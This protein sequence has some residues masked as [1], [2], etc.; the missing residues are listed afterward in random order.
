MWLGR[1]I[2][3]TVPLHMQDA[4]FRYLD[5]MAPD[6]NSFP[7]SCSFHEE[8]GISFGECHSSQVFQIE[9]VQIEKQH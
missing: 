5:I 3:Y 2:V 8:M 1:G 4:R 7:I 9:K 6:Y